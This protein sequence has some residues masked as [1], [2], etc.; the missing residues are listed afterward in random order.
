MRLQHAL[1]QGPV[2]RAMLKAA[3]RKPHGRPLETPTPGRSSEVPARSAAL[4]RD[5]LHHVGGSPAAYRSELPGH[6]F[7]QWGFP[8]LTEALAEAPYDL[9]RGLNGGCRIVFHKPIPADEPLQLR[10]R[11]ESVQDD[12]YRALLEARL[13]TSTRSAPDALESTLRVFVPLKKREGGSKNPPV[14]IAD[15]ARPI[16]TW[17]IAADA[18]V[19]FAA[20]TGDINPIHWL[21]PAARAAGFKTP[22]LHG[23]STLARAIES[24]NAAHF[25]G[26]VHR[27][28]SIDVRF[29][30][31][32]LL[33]ARPSVF[34]DGDTGFSVGTAPG[35]PCFLT[36]TYEVAP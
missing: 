11:I 7:S 12:G 21:K 2:V 31:P 32:L 19:T 28:R 18:G 34:L 33:P 27:L 8:L 15:D 13:W 36:G 20:L 23:F 14:R 4:V 6:L 10:A 1:R 16:D 25:S 9:R 17:K 3:L 30:R 22:I 29:T 35:G 5:Y 24:L 26:D